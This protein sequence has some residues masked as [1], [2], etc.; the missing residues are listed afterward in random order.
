MKFLLLLCL[1]SCSSIKPVQKQK[2]KPLEVPKMLMASEAKEEPKFLKKIEILSSGEFK[3]TEV[4]TSELPQMEEVQ[5]AEVQ[6]D[7]DLIQVKSFSGFTDKEIGKFW[8]YAKKVD[9][10][11]ASECFKDYILN[12]KT[13]I[14]NKDQTRTEFIEN[15]LSEKPLL[16]FVMYYSLS[17]TIGYTYEGSD[18]IWFNR[19]FHQ[20]FALLNS[21]S[22]LGHERGHKLGFSH[23]FNSTS[24]RPDQSPYVTGE[25]ILA[26]GKGEVPAKDE[27]EKVRV[28][29]RSFR[30]LGIKKCYWKAK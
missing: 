6:Q 23:D 13:F 25:A 26:C 24:R 18:T 21:A 30:T 16:N 15:L 28:C 19:R 8:L 4:P 3:V 11:T 2:S 22:N 17:S 5:F 1:V 20:N 14:N 10:I 9:E 27:V 7:L 29:Y 12:R